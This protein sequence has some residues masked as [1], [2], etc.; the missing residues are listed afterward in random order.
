MHATIM[1]KYGSVDERSRCGHDIEVV[2]MQMCLDD[3]ISRMRFVGHMLRLYN[4]F[5]AQIMWL[6]LYLAHVMDRS[7]DHNIMITFIIGRKL[8][9]VYSCLLK[10]YFWMG[11]W[12]KTSQ[13]IRWTKKENQK[14]NKNILAL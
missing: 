4:W 3:L 10:K 7:C 11:T 12:L 8:Y 6:V 9:W 2:I 5:R 1:K 13:P 14:T